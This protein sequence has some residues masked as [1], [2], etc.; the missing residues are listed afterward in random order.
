[1]N[2]IQFNLE[3]QFFFIQSFPFILT[4]FLQTNIIFFH[5]ISTSFNYEEIV[6]ENY[7][8]MVAIY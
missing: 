8:F 4:F 6:I 2:L 1:M 5:F 7:P 3:Q